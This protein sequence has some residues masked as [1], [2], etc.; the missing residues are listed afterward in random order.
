MMR[1]NIWYHLLKTVIILL[2][3]YLAVVGTLLITTII[4]NELKIL[5][6]T[7]VVS[8]LT[9]SPGTVILRTQI[10]NVFGDPVP[11]G[12]VFINNR[13]VQGDSTGTF[14]AA[15]LKPGRYTIQIFAG[16]YEKYSWEIQIE[17]GMNSPPI[18]YETGLWPEF[19]L[20]D[21]HIF[22]RDDSQVLGIVGYANSSEEPIYIRQATLLNPQGEV[23]TDLLHDN[24]GF[25]YYADL[26]SKVDIVEEP[27]K[28]LKWAPRM[29][30]SG[31]FPPIKGD[32]RPGLYTLEVHYGTFD[33]HKLGRYRVLQIQDHLD[34]ESNWNPHLPST[35]TD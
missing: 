33:D 16:G 8:V 28:A 21:F 4:R 3:A 35:S 11:Y 26:S 15:S 17:E 13:I 7:E 9:S 23:I 34:L 32:F 31:E 2:L 20:V 6:G 12:V 18:K 27:Q 5:D 22:F 1:P 10:R 14:E 30:L 29:W 24:D 19:F 25:K